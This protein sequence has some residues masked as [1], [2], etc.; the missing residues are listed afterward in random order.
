M[1]IGRKTL[2]TKSLLHQISIGRKFPYTKCQL[3]DKLRELNIL[4]NVD[5]TKSQMDEIFTDL[6][7]VDKISLNEM[8]H[9]SEIIRRDLIELKNKRIQRNEIAQGA[10]KNNDVFLLSTVRRTTLKKNAVNWKNWQKKTYPT[11][12]II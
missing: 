9:D 8:W 2:S 4:S 12:R 3:D 1:S 5:W 11:I 6:S 10:Y 7:R